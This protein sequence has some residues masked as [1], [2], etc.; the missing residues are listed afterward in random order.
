MREDI[1]V[2][3]G[4]SH[5]VAVVQDDVSASESEDDPLGGLGSVRPAAV[6]LVSHLWIIGFIINQDEMVDSRWV[7]HSPN[8]LQVSSMY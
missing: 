4:C 7:D 1:D 2:R 3:N 6:G 5:L 8:L